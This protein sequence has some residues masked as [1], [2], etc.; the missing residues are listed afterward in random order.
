MPVNPITGLTQDTYGK[1]KSERYYLFG[2]LNPKASAY[3]N[4][5][6]EFRDL[7]NLNFLYPGSL[8]K[9]PGSTLFVGTT[10]TGSILGGTEFQRLNGNSVIIVAANTNL[11]TVVPPNT[12][13][14]VVTGL[15]NG[16]F[17]N[18]VTFVDRLFCANG[19]NFFKFDGTNNY[20]FSLPPGATASWGVTQA[21][22]GSLT[23]GITGTFVCAY[24]YLNE[25]GYLG[26]VSNLFTLT[27]NGI[28]FNSI[29][30]YGMTQPFSGYG[31][32]A[33]QLW[34]TSMTGTDQYGTTLAVSGATQV[35]DTGFPLG[36][37]LAIPHLWFTL[38]PRYQTVYN[39]QLFLAGFSQY[40]SRVY[41]SEIA[42]PEAIQPNYYAD[43]RT[44]DGDRISGMKVYNSALTVGKLK[45]FHRVVGDN[46]TNFAIQEI[47]QEYGSLS[48]QAMVVFENLLWF[49]DEKGIVQFDGSNI[50]MI[51]DKPEPFFLQMNVNASVD[52]AQAVHYKYYNEVW[53]HIPLF[54]A[55]INSHLL[56]YDYTSQAWTR[57]DGIQASTIFGARGGQ[58][59]KTVFYGGY[60]GGIFYMGPSFMGDN[61]AAITCMAFSS[62][63]APAGQTIE[64]MYRRFWLDVDPV[65]G[66]TQAININLFSNYNSTTIAYTGTIFQSVYQTRLDFGLSSRTMAA[67]VIHTSASL[68]FKINAYTFESRYQRSV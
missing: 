54:G 56:V 49:L 18:F 12:V 53:F 60:S 23:P 52:T 9:R 41:W 20:L 38:V 45:S 34:R 21:V 47:S 64:N 37:S 6:T 30:Y 28:T 67:Q 5:P 31:I 3:V 51:S 24:G 2:G 7:S 48:N 61:G 42:E 62:F 16:A 11:Y 15:Q 14:P 46:P 32:T 36:T 13:T 29:T 55:T 65:L 27:I 25:R 43:F 33:I 4:G 68:P 26:P 50:G 58:Q 17:F 35:T 40:P 59:V 10:L 44:N 66:I 22:G 63:V 19:T 57:Y 39:N 1:F 8:T